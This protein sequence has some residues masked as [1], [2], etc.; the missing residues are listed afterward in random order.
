MQSRLV[1]PD[2]AGESYLEKVGRLRAARNQ[3]EEY[4][5]HDLLS[6]PETEEEEREP[7]A[8][9]V[10]GLE[11]GN[12]TAAPAA[13]AGTTPGGSGRPPR[14]TWHPPAYGP[15]SAPT[16]NRWKSCAPS[17]PSTGQRRTPPP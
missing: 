9:A 16:L 3:A 8:A 17:K 1:G 11:E 6:P 5:G 12:R 14:R 15:A 2:L 10:P 4:E 13:L 7:G